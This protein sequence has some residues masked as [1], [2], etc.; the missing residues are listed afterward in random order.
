[1][2]TTYLTAEAILR[3]LGRYCN[4]ALKTDCA[5]RTNWMGRHTRVLHSRRVS[6]PLRSFA[7]S[8]LQ[9]GRSVDSG[10]LHGASI[11]AEWPG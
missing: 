4:D 10:Q 6:H 2:S 7:G 5:S 8:A 1:M 9:P 11:D 3:T